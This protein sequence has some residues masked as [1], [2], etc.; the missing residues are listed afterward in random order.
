MIKKVIEWLFYKTC[1]NISIIK[2]MDNMFTQWTISPSNKKEKIISF[3]NMALG[4]VQ[5]RM[6]MYN[7]SIAAA[8]TEVISIINN[9]S[10]S[11]PRMLCPKCKTHIKVPNVGDKRT[12]SWSIKSSHDRELTFNC[13]K[14]G[15]TRGLG[16]KTRY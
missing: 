15:Y 8:R 9:M 13:T 1:D 4:V 16:L 10:A 3:I 11:E 2:V 5:E 6:P 14:C 12:L 7:T